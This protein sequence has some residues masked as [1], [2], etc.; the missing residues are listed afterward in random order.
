MYAVPT[1]DMYA[2]TQREFASAKVRL[3]FEIYKKICTFHADF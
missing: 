3:F 1:R 2:H